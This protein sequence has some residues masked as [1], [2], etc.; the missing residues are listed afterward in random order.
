MLLF[1]VQEIVKLR[2]HALRALHCGTGLRAR[3]QLPEA[4]ESS[5]SLRMALPPFVSQSRSIW[6]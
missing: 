5:Y 3:L 2:N 1:D 4:I 6:S